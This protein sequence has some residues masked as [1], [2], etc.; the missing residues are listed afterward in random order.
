MIRTPQ[1]ALIAMSMYALGCQPPP[2]ANDMEPPAADGGSAYRSAP[3]GDRVG[4]AGSAAAIRETEPVGAEDYKGP[5]SL[6]TKLSGAAAPESASG[7]ASPDDK[8][9]AAYPAITP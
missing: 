8:E 9:A 6:A 2:Y 3:P 5:N 4:D 7:D 1:L